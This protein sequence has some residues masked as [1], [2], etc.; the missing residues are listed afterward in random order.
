MIW[1]GGAN[2]VKTLYV[3]EILQTQEK[4]LKAEM[5]E[6]LS[7]KLDSSITIEEMIWQ[8][9]ILD[10]QKDIEINKINFNLIPDKAYVKNVLLQILLIIYRYYTPGEF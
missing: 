9:A 1:K 2:I 4:E 3:F 5:E 10:T 8:D 7:E 6:T